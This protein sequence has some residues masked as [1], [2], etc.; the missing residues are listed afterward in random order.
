MQHDSP[1]SVVKVDHREDEEAPGGWQTHSPDRSRRAINISSN[2]GGAI[3]AERSSK[4]LKQP[5]LQQNGS[6]ATCGQKDSVGKMALV[7]SQR[8][9]EENAILRPV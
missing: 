2:S 9:E 6:N 4:D 5:T 8:S 7:E 3:K 1:K